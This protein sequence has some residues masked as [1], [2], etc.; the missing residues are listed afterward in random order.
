MHEEVV[1][2]YAGQVYL[3]GDKK[4]YTEAALTDKHRDCVL[5][6]DKEND[7]YDELLKPIR[8][9]YSNSNRPGRRAILARVIENITRF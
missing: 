9:A 7:P 6:K 2:V 4:L 3:R 8:E 5:K 1:V